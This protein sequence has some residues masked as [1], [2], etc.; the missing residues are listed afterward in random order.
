MTEEQILKEIDGAL[1][2]AKQMGSTAA[3]VV[4]GFMALAKSIVYLAGKFDD[5]KIRHYPGDD[6][7]EQPLR[8][9]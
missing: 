2:N 1:P 3:A 8:E 6:T 9:M 7:E 5:I 4:L